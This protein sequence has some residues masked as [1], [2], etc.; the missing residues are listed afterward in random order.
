VTVDDTI[1][2]NSKISSLGIQYENGTPIGDAVVFYLEDS[3]LNLKVN[4]KTEILDCPLVSFT[5]TSNASNLDH[6]IQIVNYRNMRSLKYSNA[7]SKDVT[8][9]IG[10]G[11]TKENEGDYDITLTASSGRSISVSFRLQI[12]NNCR[13]VVRSPTSPRD[14]A[15]T[16][17][18]EALDVSWD[19]FSYSLKQSCNP[20]LTYS[21]TTK[22]LAVGPA[23]PSGLIDF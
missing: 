2:R 8:L 13:S 14:V 22:N 21:L 9:V 23:F 15:Y 3:P 6:V 20:K 12:V 11:A 16:S 5:I 7:P 1:C 10:Q 18:D 19:Q 4:F 17:G